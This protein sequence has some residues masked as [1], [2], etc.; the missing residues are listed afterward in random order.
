MGLFKIL[1]TVQ[2][3]YNAILVFIGMNRVTSELCYKLRDTFIK[4]LQKNDNF[5]VNLRL[6]MLYSNLCYSEVRY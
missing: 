3:L 5:M 4:E 2:F 6:T 1:S